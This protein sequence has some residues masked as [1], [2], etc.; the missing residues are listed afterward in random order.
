MFIPINEID[1]V[2]EQFFISTECPNMKNDVL[3]FCVGNISDADLRKCCFSIHTDL[4]LI[5]AILSVFLSNEF[6][7]GNIF[8]GAVLLQYLELQE[9]F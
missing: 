4:S 6:F 3:E 8:S 2:T 5:A 1:S 9:I 7:N